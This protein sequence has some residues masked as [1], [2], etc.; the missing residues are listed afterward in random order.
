MPMLNRFIYLSN[1]HQSIHLPVSCACISGHDAPG[2]LSFMEI[3][4]LLGYDVKRID[5]VTNY[6]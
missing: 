5:W 3:N 4:Y 1:M 6:A 2:M